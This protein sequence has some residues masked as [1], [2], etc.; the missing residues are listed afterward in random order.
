MMKQNNNDEKKTSK[1]KK[2][3][4]ELKFGLRVK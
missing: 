2:I 4:N 3:K 1:M